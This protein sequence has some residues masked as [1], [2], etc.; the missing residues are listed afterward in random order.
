[1]AND[2]TTAPEGIA[3]VD[4]DDMHDA[5]NKVKGCAAALTAMYVQ[6]AGRLTYDAE[7]FELLAHQLHEA[8]RTLDDALAKL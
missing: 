2:K 5:T 3:A 1:M 4:Y 8:A 7:L 6:D